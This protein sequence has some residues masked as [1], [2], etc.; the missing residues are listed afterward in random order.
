MVDIIKSLLSYFLTRLKIR[1]HK[2]IHFFV[3]CDIT[4]IFI[5]F[6]VIM[7]SKMFSN[8]FI[9]KHLVVKKLI[10]F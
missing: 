9:Q 2:N 6:G 7:F 5:F 3:C 1:K 4:N 10:K 8:G